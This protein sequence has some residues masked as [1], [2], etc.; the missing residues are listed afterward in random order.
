MKKQLNR[1][2]IE[3]AT[4]G[5]ILL[6][7]CRFCDTKL[8]LSNKEHV[9]FEMSDGSRYRFNLCAHC[10]KT[11]RFNT[12]EELMRVW[13]TDLYQYKQAGVSTDVLK[14]VAQSRPI[15]KVNDNAR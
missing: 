4:D 11:R 12:Q 8:T 2:F 13:A 6:H 3:L 5:T 9:T 10:K 7:V 14:R 1:D 15:R